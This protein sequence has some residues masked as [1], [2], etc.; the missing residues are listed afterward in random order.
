MSG[1]VTIGDEL[2]SDPAFWKKE[3]QAGRSVPSLIR[4]EH[5]GILEEGEHLGVWIFP[6]ASE[7][8][9]VAP[10]GCE[11]DVLEINDRVDTALFHLKPAQWLIRFQ[12][13]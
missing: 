8:A 2:R 13:G 9:F 4:W 5:D 7:R 11:G 6:D 10:V 3:L 1:A 12:G